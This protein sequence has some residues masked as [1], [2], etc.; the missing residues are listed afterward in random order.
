MMFGLP[1]IR[2]FK[3]LIE[4]LGHADHAAAYPCG[5]NHLD[6]LSRVVLGLGS[7]YPECQRQHRA[8]HGTNPLR[9]HKKLTGFYVNLL[10][11]A[12]FGFRI[13][14]ITPDWWTTLA[15]PLGNLKRFV[16]G[17]REYVLPGLSFRV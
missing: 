7:R 4:P 13:H 6:G 2:F 3:D 8:D 5:N 17:R 14:T 11:M 1:A 15:G 9:V 16:S 12:N 10:I